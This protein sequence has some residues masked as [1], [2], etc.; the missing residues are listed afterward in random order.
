[1]EKNE[2]LKLAVKKNRLGKTKVVGVRLPEKLVE[3]LEAKGVDVAETIRNLL[4][5]MADGF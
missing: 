3:K 2:L 4:E 5:R 1:M